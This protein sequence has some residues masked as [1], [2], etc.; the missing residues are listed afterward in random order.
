MTENKFEGY[1]S[2]YISKVKD[3]PVKEVLK[4]QEIELLDFYNSLKS[5]D[6][7]FRYGPKKWLSLIHI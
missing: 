3:N 7:E 5:K 1:F 2:Y 4:V 6:V